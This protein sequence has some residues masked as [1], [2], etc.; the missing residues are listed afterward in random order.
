MS[1]GKSIKFYVLLI[2][3]YLGKDDLSSQIMKLND[4]IKIDWDVFVNAIWGYSLCL[5]EGSNSFADLANFVAELDRR[6]LFEKSLLFKSLSEGLL[7]AAN[8]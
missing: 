1:Q 2:A 4:T 8:L 3:K 7:E 6:N 5:T